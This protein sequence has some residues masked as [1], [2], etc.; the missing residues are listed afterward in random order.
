MAATSAGT[1]SIAMPSRLPQLT[2]E[3]QGRAAA[4]WHRLQVAPE[5]LARVAGSWSA[6]WQSGDGL[7]VVIY[8]LI[9]LLIG[10]GIEWL[11]WCYAG[12]A[13]RAIAE[14]AMAGSNDTALAPRRAAALS[15]R[16]ALLEAC[17]CVLFALSTVTASLVFTWP[18]GVQEAVLGL[19]LVVAATR[20]TGITVRPLVNP[21]CPWLRLLPMGDAAARRVR[22]IAVGFV[23]FVAGGSSLRSLCDGPFAAPSLGFALS[24]V[25]ALGI[26]GFELEGIRL[27]SSRLNSGKRRRVVPAAS[28][29]L[30]FLGTVA[31]V[32][33]V[34][35]MLLGAPQLAR[36]ITIGF[37]AVVAERTIRALIDI[38]TAEPASETQADAAGR[39]AAYRPV[40]RR[41]AALIVIG[42]A[43]VALAAEWGVSIQ[44]LWRSEGVGRLLGRG[45]EVTIVVLLGDLAWLWARTGIDRHVLVLGV[46]GPETRSG[47]PSDP[48][49]RLATLYPLLRKA[50]LIVIVAAVALTLLSSF[51]INI[52]PLLAGAG[53]I[54]VAI[55]FGAQT[56]VRD[57]VSGIFYL[58][59]DAFRVGEYVEFGQIRGTV[60]SISPRFLRLRHHRGAIHTIPFGE[61]RWLTNQ[62][63]DWQIMKLEFRVPFE[64]DVKLVKS[65]IKRIGEEL[66]QDAELGSWLL[67]PVK[68]RGVVRMDEFCM[69]I[70]VKFMTRPG[71]GQFM[72]RREVYHR[73]LEVFDANGIRFS[74]R[75]MR[76][77]MIGGKPEE[78]PRPTLAGDAAELPMEPPLALASSGQGSG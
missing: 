19:T 29:V 32:A 50:V 77:E 1:A 70:G 26:C 49:T 41:M 15:G 43:C 20:L 53:V 22:R 76:V 24:L 36:A 52:A 38:F 30:P 14:A 27:W 67:E 68:S 56:L 65:L 40:L 16:R 18:A 66:M 63:R 10:G 28:I 72:V 54:G 9:L 21:D 33:G 34:A 46:G 39:P 44:D 42:A 11:Y 59:E 60:E 78:T 62:S 31:A 57:I 58:A 3:A 55:G 61:I 23:A 47:E 8:G 5:D 37:A 25:A 73:I 74:D 64:T 6:T 13:R 75:H 4:S 2:E 51:G 69:V 7:R 35:F 48:G 45:L 17:G 71:D 12:R